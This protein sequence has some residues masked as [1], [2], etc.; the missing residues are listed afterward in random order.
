MGGA[1]GLRAEGERLG[2][3]SGGPEWAAIG[4][5]LVRAWPRAS[6][7]GW[8]RRRRESRLLAVHLR[9]YARVLEAAPAAVLAAMNRFKVSKFRHTEARPPRREVSLDAV[10]P[11]L[12]APPPLALQ[13]TPGACLTRGAPF[14]PGPASGPSGCRPAVR[15]WRSW[16]TLHSE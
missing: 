10:A 5:G 6:G 14:R 9:A 15:A 8:G 7:C 2:A 11:C 13:G 1:F 4:L 16:D 12:A 3:W